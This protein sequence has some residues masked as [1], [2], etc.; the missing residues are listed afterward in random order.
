MRPTRYCTLVLTLIRKDV[1]AWKWPL[2]IY[3]L[4][5]ASVCLVK[6]HYLPGWGDDH[7]KPLIFYAFLFGVGFFLFLVQSHLFQIDAVSGSESFLATRPVGRWQIIL[8]KLLLFNLLGLIP[9]L[10]ATHDLVVASI[11]MKPLVFWTLAAV[12]T[13]LYH[14][15]FVPAILT[16]TLKHLI[17]VLGGLL[18]VFLG[19]LDLL[20]RY[21]VGLAPRP[22][23]SEDD[24]YGYYFSGMALFY[25]LMSLAAMWSFC[26]WRL[27]RWPLT[28][29]GV[30]VL[31]TVTGFLRLEE[32]S[33]DGY[34][35]IPKLGAVHEF[36]DVRWK[37][38]SNL[39]LVTSGEV[40]QSLWFNETTRWPTVDKL[41][42]GVIP[43]TVMS[44]AMNP[45]LG[46][47]ALHRQGI[48]GKGVNVA[49]ID[50]P[51]NDT[52][53]EY[54]GKIAAYRDFEC[55]A[56]S[57]MHGPAVASLL[58]G[59]QC[60]T[61]PG[62][63]I[64]Y[65]AV[66]SWFRDAR[67]Y[68]QALDWIVEQNRA[69]S[70][71]NKIRVVS[72][73]AA[74]SGPGSPFNK[75]QDQWDR[76]WEQAEKEGIVVLDCTTHHGIVGPCFYEAMD[77]ENPARCK[78]GFPGREMQFIPGKRLLVPASPRTTAE[79]K[80]GADPG[81][82]YMGRGGLSWSIPYCAGVLAQGW[83]LRPEKSGPEMMDLLFQTAWHSRPDL[84]IIQPVAFIN[85][86][87]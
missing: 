38:L 21:H 48:T 70:A 44:N 72:V 27:Y 86:L 22:V 35:Q 39:N 71:S 55:D 14:A 77:R 56:R 75:N 49:I 11:K 45:G 58:V 13:S 74:P 7:E 17:M 63:R 81:Y 69:L 25:L 31:A 3:L 67:Y 59:E 47:R 19:V 12:I 82:Q 66:P 84:F 40:I 10:A 41:P 50:Q 9:F 34:R 52:H 20:S 18:I 73:S 57:S 32:Y 26:R 5:L 83:Q 62:A 46:I 28:L 76:A 80:E 54:K 65:A 15:L 51:L 78:P 42:P 61:A 53:P 60:G 23:F 87:K 37:D 36:N 68:A 29:I 85:R 6:R 79:H 16:Q 2:L 43:A 24:L 1:A 4:I 33:M 64:Y 30:A 8:S